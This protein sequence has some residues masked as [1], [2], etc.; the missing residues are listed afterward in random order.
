MS[1][2]ESA[3][4]AIQA[5]L[6]QAKQ[7]LAYYQSHVAALEGTLA[8]L[9]AIGGQRGAAA[10]ESKTGKRTQKVEAAAAVKGRRGRPPKAGKVGKTKEAK[11]VKGAHELPFTGGD[12]WTDLVTSEPQSAVEILRASVA[13]LGFEPSPEQIKKLQQRMV[14]VLNAAAKDK[15]IKNSGS[16]RARRFFK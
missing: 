3:R 12:Y 14:F 4:A 1:N 5:E 16:G 11:V 7:G 8:Q 9:A 15:K 2:L 10:V 6:S 13:R